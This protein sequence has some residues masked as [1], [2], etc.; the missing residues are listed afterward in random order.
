MTKPTTTPTFEEIE[1]AIIN[2]GNSLLKHRMTANDQTPFKLENNSSVRNIY[3]AVYYHLTRNRKMINLPNYNFNKGLLI[4][5]DVGTGKT[6]MMQIFSKLMMNPN[7]SQFFEINDSHSI[8]REFLVNGFKTIDKY[9]SEHYHSQKKEI[10]KTL[11]I[12]DL[13]MEDSKSKSFGND[14]NVMEQILYERYKRFL[15]HR[16][17]THATSNLTAPQLSTKYGTRVADRFNEMFQIKFLIG[18]SQRR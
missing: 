17:I 15:S 3:K 8:V 9:S 6:L 2:I 5:G 14:A 7:G 11:C 13:G 10:P 18:E 12:D 4:I 1:S 16:M